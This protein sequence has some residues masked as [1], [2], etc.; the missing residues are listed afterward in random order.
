MVTVL[1]P[2][3]IESLVLLCRIREASMQN[4]GEGALNRGERQKSEPAGKARMAE[5]L[6]GGQLFAIF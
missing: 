1:K 2:L 6:W 4:A 3:L 5:S